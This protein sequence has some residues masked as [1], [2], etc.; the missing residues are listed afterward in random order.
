[1]PVPFLLTSLFG[2]LQPLRAPAGIAGS[3][4]GIGRQATKTKKR[5][6]T[7]GPRGVCLESSNR[8]YS[9]EPE[10]RQELHEAVCLSI[11][12]WRLAC[13][14]TPSLPT[15]SR[16]ASRFACR[17]TRGWPLRSGRRCRRPR[18]CEVPRHQGTY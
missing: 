7:F 11:E 2:G 10:P 13:C 9:C 3:P 12:F 17:A 4:A 14:V 1:V 5:R 18:G 16:A 6:A 8:L 15:A